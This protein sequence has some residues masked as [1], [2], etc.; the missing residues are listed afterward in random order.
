M[1]G[2]RPSSATNNTRKLAVGVISVLAGESAGRSSTAEQQDDSDEHEADD[3]QL[4]R[5]GVA[6]AVV[7]PGA[8]AAA[9]VLFDLVGAE[10]VVDEAAEGD[11]VAEK[12]QRGDGVAEDHHGGHDE[13]DILEHTAEGHDEA[14][15][16]ADL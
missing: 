16:F 12:L 3:D 6:H 13:E 15:G 10:L 9:E 4:A 1:A 2:T 7:G 11:A 5:G 8:L 14:G